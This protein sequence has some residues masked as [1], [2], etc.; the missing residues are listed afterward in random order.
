MWLK[1][2]IFMNI[3]LKMLLRKLIYSESFKPLNIYMAST[4]L[5]VKNIYITSEMREYLEN[6]M[7]PLVTNEKL[8]ELLKSFQDEIVKRF[9]Y[10]L[11]EKI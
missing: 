7:K 4:R 2:G 3:F 11:S 10:K 6:L 8:E 1:Y 5:Q 9:E